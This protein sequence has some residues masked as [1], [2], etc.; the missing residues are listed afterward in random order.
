MIVPSIRIVTG[1]HCSIRSAPPRLTAMRSFF[2]CQPL[3]TVSESWPYSKLFSIVWEALHPG[4][5]ISSPRSETVPKK[6]KNG[7]V[8]D[9]Y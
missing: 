2:R 7:T 1:L 4:M 5:S 9:R 3:V 6:A 8:R